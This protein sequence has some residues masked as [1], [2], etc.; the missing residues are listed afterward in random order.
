MTLTFL[1]HSER[2]LVLL[3]LDHVSES[4]QGLVKTHIAGPTPRIS[5]SQ[6][7]A[8]VSGGTKEFVYLTNSKV[9]AE[10]ALSEPKC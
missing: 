7:W 5:G 2:C 4:S 1:D 9:A 8:G 10:A 6:V 3:K